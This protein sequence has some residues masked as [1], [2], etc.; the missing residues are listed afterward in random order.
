MNIR[1]S[2]Q[3]SEVT[4]LSYDIDGTRGTCITCAEKLCARAKIL[5]ASQIQLFANQTIAEIFALS[6]SPNIHIRSYM[7]FVIHI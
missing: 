1:N 7:T 3:S 4:V 6:K 5:Q 2:P